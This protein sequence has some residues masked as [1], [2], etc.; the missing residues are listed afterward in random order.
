MQE[1]HFSPIY[2]HCD[3]AWTT[4]RDR[5]HLLQKYHFRKQTLLSNRGERARTV[6]IYPPS[7]IDMF[8]LACAR[9]VQSS[10]LLKVP[11]PSLFLLRRGAAGRWKRVC[12][13][14]FSEAHPIWAPCLLCFAFLLAKERRG[15]EVRGGIATL[16]CNDDLGGVMSN[17]K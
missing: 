2:R 7:T 16:P 4:I 5:L 12:I 14:Q 9:W 6:E 17:G 8:V 3:S 10:P 1:M 13:R 11:F 15:A